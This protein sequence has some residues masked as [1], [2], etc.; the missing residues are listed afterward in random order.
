MKRLATVVSVLLACCFALV[1]VTGA[2]LATVYSPS[3]VEV[4]YDGSYEPLR[5]VM[6][7]DAYASALELSFDRR[8]GLLAQQWH[9]G[10]TR[11]LL[12]LAV[13][14]AALALLTRPFRPRRLGWAAL[15]ALVAANA[16][17]GRRL[18][19]DPA[20]GEVPL[21]WWYAAHLL[22]AAVTAIA[23]TWAWLRGRRTAP[24]PAPDV[25][26]AV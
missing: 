9:L 16:V 7:S 5:G 8:G 6:M 18:L 10:F 12:A 1:V 14:R 17:I 20:S 26:G 4:V 3:E 25:A 2:Y 11:A 21:P 24:E 13:L 23:W 19:G 15:L 22:V